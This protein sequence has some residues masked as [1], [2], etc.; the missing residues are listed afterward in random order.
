MIID[1]S[2]R[3]GAVEVQ[4]RVMKRHMAADPNKPSRVIHTVRSLPKV[5]KLHL[6]ILLIALIAPIP[7]FATKIFLIA[8][9]PPEKSTKSSTLS[10]KVLISTKD[11]T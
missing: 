2:R 6:R 1:Q 7:L 5:S 4:S 8:W 3:P 10:K 9:S 11:A